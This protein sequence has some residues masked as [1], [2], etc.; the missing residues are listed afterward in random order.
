MTVSRE[1]LNEVIV[2]FKIEFCVFS[3]M[4]FFGKNNQ[5]G[6]HL[7]VP[8]LLTPLYCILRSLCVFSTQ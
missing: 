6:L 3:C 1:R 8:S 5:G 2:R 7:T 4:F